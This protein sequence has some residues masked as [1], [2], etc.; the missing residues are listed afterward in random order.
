MPRFQSCDVSRPC[1]GSPDEPRAVATRSFIL[2]AWM[3]TAQGCAI[4]PA[5]RVAPSKPRVASE[6]RTEAIATHTASALAA[7][8]Q[9]LS[10]GESRRWK[11]GHRRRRRS[12]HLGGTRYLSRHRG[13]AR[14]LHFLPRQ[15]RALRVR[16]RPQSFSGA[17]GRSNFFRPTEAHWKIEQHRRTYG[18]AIFWGQGGIDVCD[19]RR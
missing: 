6:P 13:R 12:P 7:R 3:I 8:D 17:L 19:L 5:P 2:F 16:G 4:S 11:C 9:S 18:R 1:D 15:E 14:A 10:A